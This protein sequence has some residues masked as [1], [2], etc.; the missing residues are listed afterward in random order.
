MVKFNQQQLR[1]QTPV[2]DLTLSEFLHLPE[3]QPASEFIHGKVIQK[4]M[5]QEE[6]SRLQY[7]FCWT[8]NEV[9]ESSQVALAFLLLRCVFEGNAI[10]P[11][12]AVFRWNRIPR[13]ESGRVANRFDSYPDWA[14]EILSP[15]QSTTKVLENLLLCSM[16]GTE[17]GWLIDAKEETI[18]G[19]FPEQRVQLFRGDE[20]LPILKGIE[21]ELKVNDVFNWLNL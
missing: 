8:V 1:G 20:Q 19:V 3:T 11:D 6:H 2:Q 7:K 4:S 21:L 12:V 5:P 16:A 15:E 14:V 18:L 13:T 10:V 9:A 17:L